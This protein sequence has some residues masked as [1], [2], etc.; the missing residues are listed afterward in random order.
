MYTCKILVGY[1]RLQILFMKSRKI[2]LLVVDYI[3]LRGK[4]TV[5]NWHFSIGSPPFSISSS[6]LCPFFLSS[7]PSILLL[8][9]RPCLIVFLSKMTTCIL[10][11]I[12]WYEIII[13]MPLFPFVL[14]LTSLSPKSLHA[15]WLDFL[16][17]AVVHKIA[18]Y[19]LWI[20]C[21]CNLVFLFQATLS[22]LIILPKAGLTEFSNVTVNE[23]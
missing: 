20:L 4:E 2:N 15:Q 14:A 23:L 17:H 16:T 21:S 12:I 9:S 13:L 19:W 10:H 22:N 7:P 5:K 18:N 3:K 8:A 11:C 6:T 1:A